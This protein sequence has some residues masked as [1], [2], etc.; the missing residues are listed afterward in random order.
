[1]SARN[2]E[3]IV[4]SERKAYNRNDHMVAKRESLKNSLI[5]IDQ[6]EDIDNWARE[7]LTQRDRSSG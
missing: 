1:M 2:E 4:L 5:K 7:A 6:M 3:L